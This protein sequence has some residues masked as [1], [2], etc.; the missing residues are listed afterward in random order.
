[1]NE[2]DSNCQICC[3]PYTAKQRRKIKCVKCNDHACSRCV[4]K[5]LKTN[6]PDIRCMFCN[7]SGNLDVLRPF[8]PYST[9]KA[10]SKLEIDSMFEKELLLLLNSQRAFNEFLNIQ[11]TMIIREILINEGFDENT[12]QNIL[13]AFGYGSEPASS[14]S[15]LSSLSSISHLSSLSSLS[16]PM[17][18]IPIVDFQ[19]LNCNSKY[20]K[21]CLTVDSPEHICDT[22]MIETINLIS[23]TCKH[24]PKCKMLIQKDSGG[25][26]QM[27]CTNCKTTFSWNTGEEV[28]DETRHNPH[29]F[30]WQRS[31]G[32]QERHP[33][34]DPCEGRFLMKNND[35]PFIIFIYSVVQRSILIMIEMS[36]RDALIR[37]G[38]RLNYIVKK[39]TLTQWKKRFAKHIST[40]RRNKHLCEI[41][42]LFLQ[43]LYYIS[44]SSID[45]LQH[46]N[47][48][49]S[50]LFSIFTEHINYI[51][52]NDGNPTNYIISFDTIMIPYS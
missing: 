6:V 16:C 18:G 2:I 17:C 40:L 48:L 12:V 43:S 21:E 22:N 7:A 42:Y 37:E 46:P 47:D 15:S 31:N 27:F 4:I 44:E 9:F 34:D 32:I 26:D 1:M 45:S 20:C 39:I 41:L 52:S 30:E 24:C 14:L 10:F 8:L 25:C 36:E 35:N 3:N 11:R 5:Y 49:L 23:R 51:M 29:F 19:C 28:I 50:I 13:N 33:N 38:L